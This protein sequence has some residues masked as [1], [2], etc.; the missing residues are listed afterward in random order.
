[1]RRH[2]SLAVNYNVTDIG[3]EEQEK[4][5]DVIIGAKEMQR[6]NIK[7]DPKGEKMGLSGFRKEF[8]EH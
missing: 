7:I 6:R 2:I 5:I 3:K 1:M 4:G 8:I